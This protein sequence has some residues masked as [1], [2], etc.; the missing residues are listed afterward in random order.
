MPTATKQRARREAARRQEETGSH[1]NVMDTHGRLEEPRTSRSDSILP[2][3]TKTAKKAPD[4]DIHETWT[5]YKTRPRAEL[6]ERL[7]VYYMAG[8][9]R[10]IADRMR[11]R[12]PDHV[13]TDDLVQQGYLGL[14][15]SIERFELERGIKFETFSRQRISGAMQDYLRSQDHL[16]R[17][18]RTRYRKIS[19]TIESY[20]VEHG[21]PPEP[22]ELQDAMQLDDAS[23]TQILN[24]RHAPSVIPFSSVI[25]GSSQDQDGTAMNN[26]PDTGADCALKQLQRS[27][28]QRWVTR[29]MD[30]RDRLIIILYYYEEMTMREI[31]L[32]IGC[33]ESRISQRL[34]SILRRLRSQLNV[35]DDHQQFDPH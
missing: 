18:V 9:V 4:S 15:E 2:T 26:T 3:R 29:G 16:P 34:D 14:V 10:R 32:A 33:S 13:D 11:A 12:L 5:A 27:D 25:T 20:R 30:R 6:R 1:R 17:L 31:G 21:R 24:D 8:H 35:E 23:F 19:T 7:I 22:A 28:L